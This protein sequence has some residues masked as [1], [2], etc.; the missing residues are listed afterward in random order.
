MR[1]RL[2]PL[3]SSAAP[4]A[5][6]VILAAA[7]SARAEDA[8]LADERSTA[9]VPGAADEKEAFGAVEGPLLLGLGAAAIVLASAVLLL[10][11]RTQR[12]TAERLRAIAAALEERERPHDE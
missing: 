4:L 1:N 9:F 10:G 11:A 5:L 7:A 12:R 8:T 2:V 3:V 6:L